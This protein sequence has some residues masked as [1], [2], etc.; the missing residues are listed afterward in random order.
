MTEQR[1]YTSDSE[2][3]RCWRIPTCKHNGEFDKSCTFCPV[4]RY[5]ILL[6]AKTVPE[7]MWDYVEH[8]RSSS[9]KPTLG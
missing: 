5:N 3:C 1:T 7:V 6:H 8:M 9:G 4:S 2:K